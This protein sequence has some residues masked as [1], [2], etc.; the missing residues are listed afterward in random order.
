MRDVVA[1]GR[2][3]R[4][5]RRARAGPRG[6]ASTCRPRSRRPEELAEVRVP[7]PDR[8]GVLA[9]VTTLAAELDVNI[10]DL[11]IAHSSEGDR[12]VLI[13]LVDGRRRPSGSTAGCSPAATGRRCRALE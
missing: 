7:V 2:P 13:L 4:P 3:R 12:G 10:A 11:E 5:A 9:E 1:D 6:P 8:P